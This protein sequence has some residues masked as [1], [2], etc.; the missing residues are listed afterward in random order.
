MRNCQ[1]FT[2]ASGRTRSGQRGL[3]GVG[4][5]RRAPA[6]DRTRA[7]SRAA[8]GRGGD[9]RRAARGRPSRW[10][11]TSCRGTSRPAPARSRLRPTMRWSDR[12]SMGRTTTGDVVRQG[13]HGRAV[14]A[15]ADERRSTRGISSACGTNRCSSTPARAR[16]DA[17][18]DVRPGG[19]DDPCR[20]V[21][22]GVERP[23]AGA[24]HPGVA[25]GAQ[26]DE[27]RR[28]SAR[29]ARV[30]GDDR[31]D[32]AD[33]AAGAHRVELGQR[34]DHP[35]RCVADGAARDAG[36]ER[37]GRV[38]ADPQE[39]LEVGVEEVLEHGVGQTPRPARRRGRRR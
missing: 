9:R 33:G 25:E 38:R 20:K 15:V 4:A 27:D 14:A 16:S 1:A 10:H 31:A 12:G 8:R 3:E 26:A 22:A 6:E 19:D 24:A 29:Y 34:R 5:R 18:V 37:A 13:A 11:R 30:P 23:A 21:A 7:P 17:G 32:L 36:R 28:V 39:A 35:N 2:F